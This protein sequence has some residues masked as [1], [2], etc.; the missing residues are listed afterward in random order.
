MISFK[1]VTKIY[2]EN[3]GGIVDINL[4]IEKGEF[5]F[6]VGP[7]GSGKSTMIGLMRKELNPDKGMI[8]VNGIP[9]AKMKRKR[10]PYLRRNI[11]V[12][13]QEYKLLPNKTVYEN[14]A[15]AMEVIEAP[16]RLMR[17]NI[18]AVLALVGLQSKANAYPDQL[19]GGE[20]QRVAIARAIVNNPPILLAD[21]PT[22]GLDPDTA[23]E[24]MTLLEEINRRG[25]TVVMATHAKNIVDQ[26]QKRVINLDRGRIIRDV[27]KGGYSDEA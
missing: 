19:S 25:T 7:S 27:K 16:K 10:I 26:M 22:G 14:I 6:I 5:V 20:A 24:I 4:D 2:G 13:F 18:P 23:D 21:E 15:F 3:D 8:V 12:V 1:N 11:G 9:T 17:R